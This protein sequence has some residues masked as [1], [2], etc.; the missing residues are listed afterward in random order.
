MTQLS[1]IAQLVTEQN[2]AQKRAH[3]IA[4]ESHKA[5]LGAA[6]NLRDELTL[7]NSSAERRK[8]YKQIAESAADGVFPAK[9]KQQMA[10]QFVQQLSAS[11]A[12]P[13]YSATRHYS[14]EYLC[15]MAVDA[16][17]T[18][19]F[20]QQDKRALLAALIV[21]S[22]GSAQTG[23]VRFESEWHSRMSEAG[24]RTF[25]EV[26]DSDAVKA[27]D[28]DQAETARQLQEAQRY[29]DGLEQATPANYQMLDDEGALDSVVVNTR[30]GAVTVEGIKLEPGEN[31]L[32]FETFGKL[33]DSDS[34][35]R[36]E[37]AGILHHAS[38][39]SIVERV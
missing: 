16:R 2:E 21:A 18:G 25:A 22:Q 15:T 24:L 34:F 6:R 39:D 20:S 31:L 30:G 36:Y 29:I 3:E 26:L 8:Q 17:T 37:V 11:V 19:G 5:A 12:N 13:T 9:Q 4:D 10:A 32:D 28:D 38:T 14:G 35:Q 23:M 1:T 27:L 7:V 33:R